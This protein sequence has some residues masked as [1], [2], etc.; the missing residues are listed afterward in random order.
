MSWSTQKNRPTDVL[1]TVGE[2]LQSLHPSLLG[3]LM[4]ADQDETLTQAEIADIVGRSA[5][6]VSTYFQTLQSLS[7]TEKRSQRNHVTEIG[8]K[9]IALV[10]TMSSQLG[11]DLSTIDWADETDREDLS[12]RLSPLHD[13]RSPGPFF[14]LDSLY[15]RG[16]VHGHVGTPQPVWVDDAI[17]DVKTREQDRGESTT[18]RLVRET[19]R[20]FDKTGVIEFDGVQLKLEDK[21]HQQA[22][23]VHELTH[24]L[25]DRDDRSEQTAT[26]VE[27]SDVSTPDPVSIDDLPSTLTREDTQAGPTVRLGYCLSA[28]GDDDQRSAPVLPIQEMTIETL[29]NRADQLQNEFDENIRLVPYWLLQ[30]DSGEYPLSPMEPSL[31]DR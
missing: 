17:S 31:A 11:L 29:V 24:F 2:I 18:T 26:T 23:L 6:T 16:D 30:T 4:V 12:E 25:N 20:R 14:L 19:I 5:P 13:S 21:G 27:E 10:S 8:K 28:N 15:E 22:W 7:L 9:V 1:V 3:A